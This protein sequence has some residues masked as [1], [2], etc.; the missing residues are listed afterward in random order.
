LRKIYS[1]SPWRTALPTTEFYNIDR[2]ELLDNEYVN[3]TI[4]IH[5]SVKM[6]IFR[7]DVSKL[8]IQSPDTQVLRLE[9]GQDPSMVLPDEG[10]LAVLD[11][12]EKDGAAD[13][14]GDRPADAIPAATAKAASP[15]SPSAA[16]TRLTGAIDTRPRATEPSAS[17]RANFAQGPAV[18]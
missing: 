5:P 15:A 14:A 16:G 17:V 3:T 18:P 6:V 2:L 1:N 10:A 7:G 4:V 8:R 13:R 11:A 9:P 12:A